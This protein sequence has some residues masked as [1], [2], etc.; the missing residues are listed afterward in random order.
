MLAESLRTARDSIDRATDEVTNQID[1]ADDI[2][3]LA[4][5][6]FVG[7]M[8]A[9]ARVLDSLADALDRTTL[10]RRNSRR[11]VVTLDQGQMERLADLVAQRIANKPS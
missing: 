1:E 9:E 3:D 6:L 10:R 11:D 4:Q 8:K 5:G 7:S 2:I